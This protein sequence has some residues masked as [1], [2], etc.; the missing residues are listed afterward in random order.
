MTENSLQ[1]SVR[2]IR[3]DLESAIAAADSTQ[4]IEAL[5]VRFLGRKGA[6][7]ALF[8]Q[9]GSVPPDQRKAAGQAINDLKQF[10]E[11]EISRLISRHAATTTTE[12]APDL[13]LPGNWP[14][15][16]SLHPLTLVQ[17][18]IKTIFQNMGFAIAD[19]PEIETEYYNFEA[20]N[21]PKGHPAREMQ[22]TLFV[23]NGF[24]LRTHTSNVQIRVMERQRPPVR[25]ISPGR[26]FRRD[27]PDAT[28]SP[29][30]HQIE[31][32][33]VDEG[34]TFADL[35]GVILNFARQMFGPDMKIRFRPS[36]FPFVEPGAEYD[37][38]CFI[39][40][41]RGCRVCKGS[42]WIEISGAGMVNPVVF[43]TI[44]YDS[45]RYTG[46]AFG[47]GVERIAMALYQVEDIRMFFEND[48]R[49]LQQF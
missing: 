12:A 29:V 10:G 18:R 3:R 19:G 39:C 15:A 17:R 41:G 27:T 22:D 33:C 45:E 4:E 21:I 25:I 14:Q 8:K 31:G 47:M 43:E 48:L 9:L 11:D 40:M 2:T 1:E 37:F 38:T 35:R 24:V 36:Y 30:F 32:L 26:C 16:G 28:H 34:I 13:T 44:G 7:S 42:G 5:R 46:Y 49:F 20:L 23:D 6:V